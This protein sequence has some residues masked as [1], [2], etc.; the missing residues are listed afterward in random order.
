MMRSR[1]WSAPR[2]L[3]L[4][5][6]LGALA[7]GCGKK[8]ST[9]PP[10][11][12]RLPPSV[13]STF[14][15]ARSTGVPFET[16]IWAR[17]REPLDSATVSATTVFLKI[18]TRRIPAT[19]TLEDSSR[20]IVIRPNGPLE[21]RRTHTVEFSPS[22]RTVAGASLDRTYFW[23][24]TTV[25]VRRPLSPEPASGA[26]FESPVA[27]L[28]WD[29]TEAGAGPVEYRLYQGADS[30]QV[31]AEATEPVI[32]GGAALLP[33]VSWE[34]GARVYWKV[35]ARNL[36]TGDE[37]AGAVWHFNVAPSD[38]VLD[39][40]LIYPRDSGYW[41]ELFRVWRCPGLLSG[42]RYGGLARFDF[43]S[44]DS[45]LVLADA[46][47]RM[48][49]ANNITVTHNA[50][51]F[52]LLNSQAPCDAR[53]PYFPPIQNTALASGIRDELN[54][55]RFV[56]VPLAAQIQA[57]IRRHRE[58]N[59]YSFRSNLTITYTLSAPGSGAYIYHLRPAGTLASRPR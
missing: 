15:V 34:R 30:A 14:P 45:N 54:Y 32:L 22:V 35:H 33:S 27:P 59:D 17:F 55:V 53:F 7:G 58:F 44:L 5:L 28:F 43:E 50:Q 40:F 9:G 38:A 36:E 56:S 18:D 29:E 2:A 47:I 13:V 26:A 16:P 21:L 25:S 4:M 8:S 31:A 3:S 51:V 1:N 57:R 42:S 12:E 19:I 23:Q 20:T 49:T 41:D 24:F 39:S 48:Y 52:M 37:A 10:L 11:E 6:V 46:Q